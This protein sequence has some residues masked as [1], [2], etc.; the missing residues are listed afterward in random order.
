LDILNS[1]VLEEASF[2]QALDG[3]RDFLLWTGPEI[4]NQPLFVET[5]K[6]IIFDSET[7]V[8]PLNLNLSQTRAVKGRIGNQR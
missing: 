7:G 1:F 8:A 5:V 3:R 4:E 6:K 2:A